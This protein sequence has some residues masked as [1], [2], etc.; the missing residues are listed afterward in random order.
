MDDQQRPGDEGAPGDAPVGENLCP[1]C[2]GSGKLDGRTCA[3]CNG[4]GVV[5]EGVGGA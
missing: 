1:E 3:H 5:E 4:T 2:N